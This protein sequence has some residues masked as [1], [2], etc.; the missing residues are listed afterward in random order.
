M[1]VTAAEGGDLFKLAPELR[2]MIYE[3]YFIQERQETSPSSSLT[4]ESGSTLQLKTPLLRATKL[5]R[6]DAL[7]SFYK[8]HTF[9]IRFPYHRLMNHEK[10]Q[11]FMASGIHPMRRVDLLNH[12]YVD[13]TSA[14]PFIVPYLQGFISLFPNLRLLILH[15]YRMGRPADQLNLVTFGLL[16]QLSERLDR[17]EIV[18]Y[19]HKDNSRK[20]LDALQLLAPRS[21]WI[22][23]SLEDAEGSDGEW[24]RVV[25]ALNRSA[26]PKPSES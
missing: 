18:L 23:E 14:T 21:R 15:F 25:W 16:A 11:S 1:K 6:A 26:T 12:I 8:C 24:K 5:L 19:H 2:E 10:L 4:G 17:L 22:Q 3:H 13:N 20:Y 9:R 7:P